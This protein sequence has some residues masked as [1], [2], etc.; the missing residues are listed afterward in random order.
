MGQWTT[1]EIAGKSADIFEPATPRAEPVAV[2]H[3]HGHGLTTLKDNPEYSR[4]LDR[5]QFH[6]VCPHGQRSW[7]LD[8]VCSEFDA[9]KT[10]QD[11]LLHDVVPW[12]ESEWNIQPPQIALT[13]I[14]M[15]GQGV[16]HFAF[17]HAREFPTV[18]AISPAIDFHNWHGQGL[19]LDEMFST[20]EDA[21]QAT[22][23]LHIH[24]LNYPRR[25]FVLC[26][27]TDAAWID[28]SLRLREKLSASGIL[29]EHDLETSHGG[30]SWEYFN[31][32]AAA[33]TQ[34]IEDSV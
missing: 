30:H 7:W 8:R 17:Q 4:E 13:G 12:I 32:M 27:P 31:H 1:I 22:A 16:L 19:P 6:C 18:V 21:R 5:H 11:F 33:V 3:L 28:S 20:A 14:S 29:L 26:D 9:Q 23:I 24:P 34:F 25:M 15:G 2:L 10:P